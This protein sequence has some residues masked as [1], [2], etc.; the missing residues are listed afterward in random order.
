VLL[1]E[2]R[3]VDFFK[4]EPLKVFSRQTNNVS[5]Q[6]PHMARESSYSRS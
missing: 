1:K 4:R 3:L 6:N 2:V 5:R